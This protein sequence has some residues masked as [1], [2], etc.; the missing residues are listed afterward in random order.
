MCAHAFLTG[1]ILEWNFWFIVLCISSTLIDNIE[2]VLKMLYFILPLAMYERSYC[3]VS[4]Q[5]LH[6][7]TLKF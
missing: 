3:S 7:V 2:L 1:A 6:I 5:R 4:L